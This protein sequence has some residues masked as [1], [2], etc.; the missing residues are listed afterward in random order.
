MVCGASDLPLSCP[1]SPKEKPLPSPCYAPELTRR[2]A[3]HKVWR[4]LYKTQALRSQKQTSTSQHFS[5][6]YK[7]DVDNFTS[8]LYNNPIKSLTEQKMKI[9]AMTMLRDVV[10]IISFVTRNEII[11]AI[12][13]DK[14]GKLRP[15]QLEQLTVIE[16]I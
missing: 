5:K 11:Y 8:F 12:T 1:S 3:I 7:S 13:V 15:Y 2:E 14:H 16:K 9:K 6:I 4:L 10:T